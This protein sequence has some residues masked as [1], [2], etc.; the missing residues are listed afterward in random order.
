[1]QKALLKTWL[2]WQGFFALY[3]QKIAGVPSFVRQETPKHCPK[4]AK[5]H[6]KRERKT[7]IPG[8]LRVDA[9]NQ[10][11]KVVD[12]A[13]SPQMFKSLCDVFWCS[14][15]TSVFLNLIHLRSPWP[16][17]Y[18][19]HPPARRPAYA[20]NDLLLRPHKAEQ[21]LS[22][23]LTPPKRIKWKYQVQLLYWFCLTF[24]MVWQKTCA[25]G[26]INL[27]YF[28]FADVE[29]DTTP[30]KGGCWWSWVLEVQEEDEDGEYEEDEKYGDENGDEDD[31]L[32]EDATPQKGGCWCEWGWPAGWGCEADE[33]D[34]DVRMMSIRRMNR[35]PNEPL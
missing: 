28:S 1:M 7:K 9:Q 23:M 20:L 18:T 30:Q 21:N 13:W 31:E 3:P 34:E 5:H 19:M 12:L 15:T 27:Y 35:T 24:P 11:T 22:F 8:N 32:V 6:A 2:E 26:K 29:D 33:A 14:F 16:S 4:A 17:S 10:D 25:Q